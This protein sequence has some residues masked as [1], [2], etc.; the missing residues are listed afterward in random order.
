MLELV[1]FTA[2]APTDTAVVDDR[3]IG[4]KKCG[5]WVDAA[6]FDSTYA[7]LTRRAAKFAGGVFTDNAIHARTF[8][9]RDNSANLL[10]YFAPVP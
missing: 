2:P 10:Q 5:V 4:L 1:H 3:S 9:V 7:R 8:I 6:T